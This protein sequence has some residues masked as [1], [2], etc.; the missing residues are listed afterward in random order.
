[1]KRIPRIK[2][3][4]SLGINYKINPSKSNKDKL[5]YHVVQNWLMNGFQ[6]FGNR[7]S[8]T[9]LE[10]TFNID[11][12]KIY[13]TI[14]T[15]GSSFAMLSK[16]SF[17]EA[18]ASEATLALFGDILALKPAIT[19][20]MELI[21]KSQ[22]DSYKPFVTSE[23]S[24]TIDLNLKYNDQ[25]MKLIT[26]L[27][28]RASGQGMNIN[29]TNQQNQQNNQNYVTREDAVR[30]IQETTTQD[31]LINQGKKEALFLEHN[32]MDTPEVKALGAAELTTLGKLGDKN[33]K[34]LDEKIVLKLEHSERRLSEFDIDEYGSIY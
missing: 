33:T 24:K 1:M 3:L 10:S 6:I 2:G 22:G 31:I 27:S 15:E 7:L 28:P 5:E 34:L 14:T 29:I 18:L 16:P 13:D 21:L 30:I 8:I 9:E 12:N 26:M 25:V 20:Q 11:K 4:T 17:L 19:R 23:V 32:L